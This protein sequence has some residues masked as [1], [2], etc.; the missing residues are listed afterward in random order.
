ML[1]RIRKM[2]EEN[3]RGFTVT[4]VHAVALLIGILAAIAIPLFLNQRKNAVDASMKSD[5]RSEER[6][7]GKECRSRRSQP[8]EKKNKGAAK[9][10]TVEAEDLVRRYEGNNITTAANGTTRAF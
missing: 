1:A 7:V 3:V 2:Q 5:V 10:V 8:P 9:S 4:E 6:R